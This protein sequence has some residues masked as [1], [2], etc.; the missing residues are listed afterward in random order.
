MKSVQACNPLAGKFVH[1]TMLPIHS[2][3]WTDAYL[4][5]VVDTNSLRSVTGQWPNVFLPGNEL[6]RRLVQTEYVSGVCGL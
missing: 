5:T 2:V 4:Q 3:I 6:L 1:F